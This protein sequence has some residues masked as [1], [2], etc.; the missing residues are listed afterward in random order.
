[1]DTA[2]FKK[3]SQWAEE[4]PRIESVLLVGSWARGEN[5]ASSDIDLVVLTDAKEE[6]L[7]D[8][9]WTA[10]FGRV[11]RQQTESYGA[12]TSVRVWYEDGR[13][14]EFGLV[15]PSWANAPLDGGTARVLRDGYR[16]LADKK[17]R[18]ARLAVPARGAEAAEVQTVRA[19]G[20]PA[21]IRYDGAT[22]DLPSEQLLRLFRA[23]GWADG[24][25]TPEMCRTFNAP[26]CRSTLVVS[27]WDGDLLVGAVRV[28]SDGVIRSVVYDLIV[29]PAYQAAG[30]G[31]ELLR[32]C[33]A[34]FP[35]TEW[36]IGTTRD[37]A[38]Y[39]EKLGFRRSPDVYL[40]IPSIY[41]P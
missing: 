6:L 30:I 7:R 24:T 15:L 20:K 1:M 29:D 37:I 19:D 5:R 41:A 12:C 26:F 34:R 4:S 3:I 28:L 21:R 22:K 39:Y 14:V 17:G 31:R 13:E 35:G 16:V 2:I 36:L 32:R 25:E 38:G 23:A 9:S 18:F 27:A 8:Q 33:V 40:H 11:A 10:R